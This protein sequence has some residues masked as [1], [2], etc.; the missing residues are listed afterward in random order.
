MSNHS[1]SS[2]ARRRQT[3]PPISDLEG[4]AIQVLYLNDTVEDSKRYACA[5]MMDLQDTFTGLL[6]RLEQALLECEQIPDPLQRAI[7]HTQSVLQKTSTRLNHRLYNLYGLQLDPKNFVACDIN[8]LVECA[9][10]DLPSMANFDYEWIKV[11]NFCFY[12]DEAATQ[13]MIANI[14]DVGHQAA[15]RQSKG[16]LKLWTTEHRAFHQLHIQLDIAVY[17]PRR[18]DKRWS[19]VV[20]QASFRLTLALCRKVMSALKGNVYLRPQAHGTHVV[21]SFPKIE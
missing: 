6:I 10:A 13:A 15:Y 12:S 19:N 4:E 1:I 7:D 11:H 18:D 20:P 9:L 5:K 16:K 21:L 17:T 8:H 2:K 14:F 3:A